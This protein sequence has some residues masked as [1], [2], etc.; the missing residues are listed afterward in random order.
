MKQQSHERNERQSDLGTGKEVGAF[1]RS[2][3]A[4]DHG[5]KIDCRR[6]NFSLVKKKKKRQKRNGTGRTDKVKAGVPV[7]P[8]HTLT[9]PS[10][11]LEG[12]RCQAQRKRMDDAMTVLHRESR[13]P[14]PPMPC[15]HP[16][17]DMPG[18][19]FYDS[20]RLFHIHVYVVT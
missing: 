1:G 14:V 4:G 7:L 2:R 10:N 6:Q 17:G 19:L 3:L 15:P 8:F 18:C 9:R 20:F 12:R 13:G 11:K 16:G 5:I